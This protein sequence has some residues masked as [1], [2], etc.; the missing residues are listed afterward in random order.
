MPEHMAATCRK[1]Q[2]KN[3]EA[4]KWSN[5]FRREFMTLQGKSQE[6]G[7]DEKIEKMSQRLDFYIRQSNQQRVE[8]ERIRAEKGV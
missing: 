2:K 1:Q 4:Y 5:I 8:L 6:A 7:Q 3:N